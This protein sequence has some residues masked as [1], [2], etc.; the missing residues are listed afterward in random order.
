MP[1]FQSSI[2]SF[3]SNEIKTHSHKTLESNKH[4]IYLQNNY[5]ILEYGGNQDCVGF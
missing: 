4:F 2:F 1:H 5:A 3:L